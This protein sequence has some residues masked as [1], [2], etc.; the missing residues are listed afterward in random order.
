MNASIS[1]LAYRFVP[2]LLWVRMYGFTPA[3]FRIRA[4]VVRSQCQ[5]SAISR[6]LISS[7]SRCVVFLL[8]I[9]ISSLCMCQTGNCSTSN[10][11]SACSADN[12]C[13]FSV[14]TGEFV[15][16]VHA[17]STAAA[18][19]CAKRDCAGK[20]RVFPG[21]ITHEDVAKGETFLVYCI[22]KSLTIAAA[23]GLIIV[24]PDTWAF[25]KEMMSAD[26]LPG[27]GGVC[28][29]ARVNKDNFSNIL[30]GY[31][32]S[33][34][35]IIESFCNGDKDVFV[36]LVVKYEKK[37]CAYF[38]NKGAADAAEDLTQETFIEAFNNLCDINSPSSFKFWIRTI[39][40]RKW[41]KFLRETRYPNDDL[42]ALH[43][44]QN[45]VI[46]RHVPTPEEIANTNEFVEVV[47]FCVANLEDNYRLL[48]IMNFIEG[49]NPT[50]IIDIL[51]ITMDAFYT[52]KHRALNMIRECV[53][54]TFNEQ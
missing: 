12:P 18:Y 4:T 13:S 34:E 43:A 37:L 22:K 11:Y 20:D 48:I 51:A 49:M 17:S 30:R 54:R 35:E 31:K 50:M 15:T 45:A 5:S 28:F 3:R 42:R 9:F 41:C 36:L 14:N 33:D 7:L 16:P 21:E 27:N 2:F 32:L 44:R 40:W 29:S 19:P 1:S 10:S 24:W 8:A 38:R 6:R 39:A 46:D 26:T 47:W 52:R 25:P 23:E 53:D